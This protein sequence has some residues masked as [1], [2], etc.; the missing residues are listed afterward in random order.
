MASPA[1]VKYYMFS[2]KVFGIGKLNY[3]C[4]CLPLVGD[5]VSILFSWKLKH[6]GNVLQ[7]SS[8]VVCTYVVIL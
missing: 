6:Y 5:R 8:K 3:L 2:G 4:L 1:F 7:L